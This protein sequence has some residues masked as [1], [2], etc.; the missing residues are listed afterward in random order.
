MSIF[1]DNAITW[2]LW[3]VTVTVRGVFQRS[4]RPLHIQRFAKRITGLLGPRIYLSL[5]ITR[6]ITVL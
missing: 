4:P 1:E 3:K 2:Y 6:F 5:L